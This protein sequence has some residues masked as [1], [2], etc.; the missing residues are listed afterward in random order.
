MISIKGGNKMSTNN[1][2]SPSEALKEQLFYKPKN[3]TVT[4]DEAEI[5]AADEYCDGYKK[6][7]NTAKTEREF[8]KAA[9]EMAEKKGFVPF[10]RNKKLKAGDKVYLNNRNKSLILAV[11]GSRHITDGVSI[12]AAHI[13]SPRLDLK[14]NPLYEDRNLA[15]F[16]THYYGGIK[17]YQWTAMP[18]ALHGVV[19]LKDGRT[20][21]VCIGE[22]ET[23]PV[24]CVTDLLPHL[25]SEQ[26]KKSASEFIKGED[27]NIL[28][29]SR[30]F[31][32]DKGSELVKLNIMKILYERYGILES[33][34]LSAELVAVPAYPA[35]DVGLDRSMIG[36]YGHDDRVC[37]YPALTSILE[38]ENP[39]YTAITILADKEEIGS[40]GNTGMQSAFFKYF[41]ADIA[42][43][44]G[45]E[46]RHVLSNSVCLSADVNVAYDPL[47]SDVV[48]IRNCAE[49]NH[50]VALTKYTG[51]RGKVDTSDASAEF[52]AMIRK[53]MD[54][55]N[56]L[57]QIGE[58]GKV[59][60]GGGGT[61]AKYIA[62]LDVDTVDMG[63]PVLS[64]HSPFEV[65]SKLDVYMA[66]KAF[67]TLFGRK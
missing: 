2:K 57:W 38:T 17:K 46:C 56:V 16:D 5:K 60:V 12:A 67:A 47:Y 25:A 24:F 48:E 66:H 19:A 35:R 33:D 13:D 65:V 43:S 10:D 4:L 44:F 36:G 27:L 58:L 21:D 49:L 63:V 30:P 22:D 11:I 37:A 41:V 52:M 26:M 45:E 40:E 61:V 59:D 8:V 29:G 9:I 1:E 55:N 14:P 39:A 15:Y 51:S 32:D 54:D 50:G 23:D 3:A 62:D 28:I 42:A 6:F 53:L 31:K 64:M 18:L 7:L 34:F 20:I